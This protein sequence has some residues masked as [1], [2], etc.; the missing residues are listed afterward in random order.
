ME[1]GSS[2]PRDGARRSIDQAR[3]QLAERSTGRKE[4]SLVIRDAIILFWIAVM[5]VIVAV[6][7]KQLWI[8]GLVI[9]VSL[10]ERNQRWSEARNHLFETIGHFG[11]WAKKKIWAKNQKQET[12]GHFWPF[13]S[14]ESPKKWL[15]DSSDSVTHARAF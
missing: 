11:R 6:F 15:S 14:L 7:V 2:T 5:I 13:E 12:F 1:S 10:N 8:K 9:N 4:T 3:K